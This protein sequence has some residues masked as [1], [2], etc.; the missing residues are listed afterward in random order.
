M[1]RPVTSPRWSLLIGLA[2][3]GLMVGLIAAAF[4][5]LPQ[6]AA[7]A[8]APG[9][10]NI[11]SRAPIRLTF[12]HSMTH[13]SVEA[14]FKLTPAQ[15]GT[16]SWA[17]D[18][19]TF[20][21]SQ[22]WPVGQVITVSV[23]GSTGERGLPL[24]GQATWAFTVSQ[25]RIAYLAGAI[26][27]LWTLA[28]TESAQPQQV[29]TE[30]VGVA[31]Y[32]ISPDGQSFIYAAQRADGGADL[33]SIHTDGTLSALV[34][35]CPD[36]ACLS[37]AISPDGQRVAYQRQTLVSSASGER[38]LGTSRLH[39]FALATS[40][41][42]TVGEDTNEARTPRWGPDGRLSY[43]DVTR[44]AIVVRDLDTGAVTY[45]PDTSGEMGTWSPDSQ[46][47]VFPELIFP[48]EAAPDSALGVGEAPS[49]FSS[50]LLRVTIATNAKVDLSGPGEVDDGSPDYSPSGEWLA[51]G[52]KGLGNP[53]QWTPGR[54]V[55][56]MQPD[57]QGAHAL[58]SDPLYNHSALMWNADGTAL[59]YM[60]FNPAAP[61]Q[62]AEIWTIGADGT[63][64]RR[65][66]MGG[67]LP[68]WLP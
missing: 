56:L 61:E 41:D 36:I 9:A 37:P 14:A 33:R 2:A 27:N 21:P 64:A 20:T 30:T 60:R 22:P 45:I 57:G 38:V 31:G 52:S 65:L 39:V 28:V 67:Y 1:L 58:T 18:T 26:P 11:S 4:L 6:L 32:D 12:S 40:Q 47:I 3:A 15:A 35:D 5:S 55:W 24:Q 43:Y 53:T 23:A 44:Q 19:L 16:F 46:S 10:Q 63:G 51:F 68:E 29:T 34:L 49:H 17:G 48:S 50:R 54:Q 8:P 25:R 42:M 66:V 59:V 7:I 62:P 13:S